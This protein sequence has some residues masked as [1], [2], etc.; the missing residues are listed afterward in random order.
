[1][2]KLLVTLLLASQVTLSANLVMAQETT[3]TET[4]V[5]TTEV[6]ETT[7]A[8]TEGVNSDWSVYEADLT[9]QGDKIEFEQ[10]FTNDKP[11]VIENDEAKF[12]VDRIAYYKFTNPED[13][14]QSFNGV[15]VEVTITNKTDKEL[16][17][18]PAF[19]GDIVG[20]DRAISS[21]TATFNSEELDFFKK[22]MAS[23]NVLAP[24]SEIKGAFILQVAPDEI[25]TLE[26]EGVIYIENPV[27]IRTK[28]DY[29]TTVFP[30][31]ITP[32][33]ISVEGI[34]SVEEQSKFYADKATVNKLGTKTMV[35]EKEVNE[36]VSYSDI[37]VTLNGYQIV[38]FVPNADEASR[39]A[40]FKDG[41][42]LMTLDVTVKN[43]S[44]RVVRMENTNGS[45]TLNDNFR[46]LNE[47]ML[48]TSEVD[49]L[50]NKGDEGQRYI[51]FAL[52]KDDYELYKERSMTV[53][54]NVYNENYETINE[55]DSL[56]FNL[57]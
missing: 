49:V 31:G 5:E 26:K 44:D 22:V 36:T 8:G 9:S 56:L 13:T 42:V 27:V 14:A 33:A 51:V 48:E 2:K 4:D 46:F 47:G 15:F 30:D 39:Y 45:L 50:L 57:K 12:S 29:S 53:S 28:D 16:Y 40:D 54:I 38:D 19:Y 7:V 43:N 23:E 52:S 1:M 25:E 35:E 32:I 20:V 11:T 10:L 55:Y 41:V 37:D 3:T 18:Q 21:A 24:N 17:L 6:A 34:A